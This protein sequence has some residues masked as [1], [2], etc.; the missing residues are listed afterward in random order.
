ME[1]AQIEHSRPASSPPPMAFREPAEPARPQKF[2]FGARRIRAYTPMGRMDGACPYCRADLPAWPTRSGPC[3]RCGGEIL[4]RSRPLDRERVL[5]TEAEAEAL[6]VEWEL[7]RE[8]G[9]SS[10]LR[11]LL[12]DQELESERDAMRIRF[13][14]E[15]NQFEVASSL[16][17]HRAFE[18]MRRLELGSFRDFGLAKASL[19]DQQGRMAEALA[20]YLGVCFLDLNGARNP[21]RHDHN[22]DHIRSSEASVGFILEHAFL[23]PPV[24]ARCI[25]IIAVLDQ[26][27][28]TVRASFIAVAERQYQTLRPLR[29]PHEAWPLLGEAIF[30]ER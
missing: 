16:I 19:L 29:Q 9:G 21:P 27:E 17:S 20:G 30:G 2:G 1:L 13:G 28:E 12:D 23:A 10:P 3:P 22:G 7:Y 4:V 25:Q 14:R 6:E 8:R 24:I 26:D 5:V 11:P 15:P 18:H